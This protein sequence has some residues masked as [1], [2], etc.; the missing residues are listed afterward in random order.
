MV[1]TITTEERHRKAWALDTSTSWVIMHILLTTTCA[2]SRGLYDVLLTL[3]RQTAST[4]KSPLLP[5]NPRASLSV[6]T[7][8]DAVSTLAAQCL[9]ISGEF[10]WTGRNGGDDLGSFISNIEV[11]VILCRLVK[12]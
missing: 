2:Y 5:A 8:S 12:L 6:R 10:D 1:S 4:R 9:L 3:H 11:C 7:Q